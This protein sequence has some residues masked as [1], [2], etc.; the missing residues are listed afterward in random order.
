MILNPIIPIWLMAIICIGLLLLKRKGVWPYIRQIVIVILLFVINLRIMLPGEVVNVQEQ[1][2]NVHVLFVIDD[3]ISML[4]EDYDGKHTRLEGV[5]ED[6]QYIV[7]EL[8]GARFSVISFHNTANLLSPF[9]NNAEYVKSTIASI[10]PLDD[11]YA[12]GSSMNVAKDVML[13]TLQDIKEKRDTK[14]VLFFIS[15]GE[16]TDGSNLESFTEV[17][18]YVSN[19]AVFGYGTEAGGNMHVKNYDDELVLVEDESGY[20]NKPAVSKIDEV[21]LKKLA[22]DFGIEYVNRN[23]GKSLDSIINDVKNSAEVIKKS[24]D[25]KKASNQVETA[26]DIYYFFVIPLLILLLYEA[27]TLIRKK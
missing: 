11:L 5:K 14:V 16:V 19:G 2:M 8:P 26:T 6:C 12:R 21:N 13:H 1:K 20:D 9:T 17:A 10:Y 15:D 24:S 23:Q 7:D 27:I 22:K 3:T 25:E 18:Q 4:A